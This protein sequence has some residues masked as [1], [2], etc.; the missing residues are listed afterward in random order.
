MAVDDF[1]KRSLVAVGRETG[2]QGPIR[3]TGGGI[4]AE[5]ADMAE[6]RIQS[7][8]RHQRL[9]IILPASAA[10]LSQFFP[11]RRPIPPVHRNLDAAHDLGVALVA[12]P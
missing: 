2:K 1:G 6:D 3:Q 8:L 7:V 12:H 11:G 10:I 9:A 5:A 4:T